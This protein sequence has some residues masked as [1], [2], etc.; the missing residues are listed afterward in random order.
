MA[1]LTKMGLITKEQAAHLTDAQAEHL[2]TLATSHLQA[3]AMT[4]K[5]GRQFCYFVRQP[6]YDFVRRLFIL[7]RI[8]PDIARRIGRRK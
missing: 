7:E 6:A 2:A 8:W 3:M 5:N 4:D 1:A